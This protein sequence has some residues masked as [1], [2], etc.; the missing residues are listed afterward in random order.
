MGDQPGGANGDANQY[1]F[2][3]GRAV[4][5]KTRQ[6]GVLGFGGEVA[7]VDT[8]AGGQGAYTVTASVGGA[9]VT[10]TEDAVQRKQTPSYWRGVFASTAAGLRVVLTKFITDQNVAVST[11]ELASTDGAAKDVAL[12][13]AS[14]FARTVEDQDAELTGSVPAFNKL[15]HLFP[16]FSGDA[17]E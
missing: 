10:L 16:R 14:P 5:V 12:T 9:D 7:Y 6:P 17:T 13:A 15:T 11:L 2:S 4:F 1:L 3:R 8:I